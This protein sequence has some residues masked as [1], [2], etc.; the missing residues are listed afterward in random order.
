MATVPLMVLSGRRSQSLINGISD[1]AL[2]GAAGSEPQ[3]SRKSGSADSLAFTRSQSAATQE[4]IP[5]IIVISPTS[6][7][8]LTNL[9]TIQET[10]DN[11]E[12]VDK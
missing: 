6:D 12:T 8:S 5:R 11:P 10:V 9:E 3:G 4:S 7:G 2:R 1:E